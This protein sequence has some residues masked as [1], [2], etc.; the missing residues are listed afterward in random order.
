MAPEEG[1]RISEASA[2]EI[3][4]D[5]RSQ[6]PP[7]RTLL[8]VSPLPLLFH[9]RFSPVFEKFAI[10]FNRFHA[11]IVSFPRAVTR[12]IEISSSNLRFTTILMIRMNLDF[13]KYLYDAQSTRLSVIN[14]DRVQ[15]R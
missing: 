3:R 15:L 8:I 12:S 7:P 9:N 6:P 13:Q 2:M 11:L 10:R 4:R 5:I 14:I 1:I